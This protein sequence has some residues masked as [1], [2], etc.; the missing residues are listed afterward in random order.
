MYTL[1]GI[2][3]IPIYI[4]LNWKW[5][6]EKKISFWLNSNTFKVV[7]ESFFKYQFLSSIVTCLIIISLILIFISLK[8]SEM[9]FPVLVVLF[10]ILLYIMKQIALKKG[11]IIKI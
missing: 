1:F 5:F 9:Y 8:I 2:I 7:K 6:R 11:Y 3:F 4:F 10:Y